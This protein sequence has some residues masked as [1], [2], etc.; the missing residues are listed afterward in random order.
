MGLVYLMNAI[1][2]SLFG[3]HPMYCV[4]A[5]RN[6]ELAK[7]IFPKWKCVFYV[8]D[9]VP[10]LT[11]TTLE[12]IGAV[13]RPGHSKIKNQMFWRFLIA[14]DPEVERFIVRDPDSR[15]SQR[16]FNAVSAWVNS[17]LKFHSMRDHPA[18]T[19]PLGG[20]LWGAVKGA[21]PPIEKSITESKLATKAYERETAY[22]LDQTF[23]TNWIYPVAKKSWMQHDSCRRNIYPDALP[24]PDGCRFSEMRFVGEIFDEKEQPNPIHFQQRI[25]WMTP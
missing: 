10:S 16:E 24:F 12:T 23:L 3:N 15:L 22:G 21:C 8:D 2:Y 6:A 5:I 1:A 17:G 14:D 20:G 13:V 7:K 4:G 25:N 9:R 19:L 18:H 11:K